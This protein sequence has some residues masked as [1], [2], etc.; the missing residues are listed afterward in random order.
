MVTRPIGAM[1]LI[2][3][4]GSPRCKMWYQQVMEA[5]VSKFASTLERVPWP[6]GASAQ[7]QMIEEME[8]DDDPAQFRRVHLRYWDR[9]P[10]LKAFHMASRDCGESP[11]GE[12]A[13][14]VIQ[15]IEHVDSG[16]GDIDLAD[17]GG[18]EI[19]T[20]EKRGI[21]ASFERQSF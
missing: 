20:M 13:S 18:H 16:L 1:G 11:D 8:P 6:Q 7:R 2:A 5:D 21:A 4:F 19:R 3:Y 12:K 10:L 14:R 17:L 9:M 15:A